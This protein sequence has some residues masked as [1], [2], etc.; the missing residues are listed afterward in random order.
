MT[1]KKERFSE[2]SRLALLLAQRGAEKL[3]HSQIGTEHLLLG[4]VQTDTTVAAHILQSMG[5]GPARVEMLVKQLSYSRKLQ[6]TSHTELTANVKKTLE[7][8][9]DRARRMGDP[10][11]G[12]GHLLLGLLDLRQGTLTGVMKWLGWVEDERDVVFEI[13]ERVNI[14][15]D[16]LRQRTLYAL[17]QPDNIAEV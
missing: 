10:V 17:R 6:S 13:L 12:T 4:L 1:I 9:V 5:L 14:N 16:D 3:E 15:P 11:I 2:C 8:A 7:R